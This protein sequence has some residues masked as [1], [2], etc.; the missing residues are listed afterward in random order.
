MS[1]SFS[2]WNRRSRGASR[3]PGGLDRCDALLEMRHFPLD[4]EDLRHRGNG[5]R[6]IQ[7]VVAPDPAD[8]DPPMALIGRLILTS[9][10]CQIQGLHIARQGR[11]VSLADEAK[12]SPAFVH[13]VLGDL[14]LGEA[15][16]RRDHLPF[17][18]QIIE[19]GTHA[20]DLMGLGVDFFGVRYRPS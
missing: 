6:G 10:C 12:A 17:D 15:R 2:Y 1:K 20:G 19:H 13:E 4:A 9:V 7:G 18:L 5:A 8:R 14:F 3:P 11:L 16:I